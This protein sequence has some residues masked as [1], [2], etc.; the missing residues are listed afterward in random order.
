M[1]GHLVPLVREG[2]IEPGIGTA[3]L[4]L[5]CEV[6]LP[7]LGSSLPASAGLVAKPL[8]LTLTCAEK[9]LN[10]AGFCFAGLVEIV[11]PGA[12]GRVAEHP[13]CF[14]YGDAGGI[15]AR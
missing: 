14:G 13:L 12:F 6:R 1:V 8:T 11:A 15:L 4:N 7:G 3:F 2:R 5:G 10:R 9:A